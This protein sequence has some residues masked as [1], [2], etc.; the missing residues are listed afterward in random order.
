MPPKHLAIL[1]L[2]LFS[3]ACAPNPPPDTSAPSVTTVP[4]ARAIL[5]TTALRI[6]NTPTLFSTYTPISNTET[7][8]ATFAPTP[9]MTEI[10]EGFFAGDPMI[11]IRDYDLGLY[12][13]NTRTGYRRPLQTQYG[14]SG[15]P[16]RWVN[17]GCELIV[18]VGYLILR[19]DLQGNINRVLFDESRV[20]HDGVIDDLSISPTEAWV[21]YTVKQGEPE[22]RAMYYDVQDIWV[23]SSD[24]QRGPFQLTER[25]GAVGPSQW[26]SDGTLLAYSDWDSNNVSQ[27]YIWSP[28]NNTEIQLTQLTDADVEI[29]ELVLEIGELSWSPDGGRIAFSF[30]EREEH[31]PVTLVGIVS[32][33]DSGHPVSIFDIPGWGLWWHD[34]LTIAALGSYPTNMGSEEYGIHWIDVTTGESTND[35]LSSEVPYG[36]ITMP[37]PL[38][39]SDVGFL[40][41]DNHFY[42]YD[43]ST[44]TLEEQADLRYFLI[45][46]WLPAPASFPGEELCNLILQSTPPTDH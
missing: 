3:T 43:I 7:P 46:E 35:F 28:D 17:N 27:L 8:T 21:A 33:N 13:V 39:D 6:T 19:V 42:I 40:G 32:I 29:G 1:F 16:Y 20:Q 2:L 24:G 22:G 25:G 11:A 34:P 37:H 23:V 44:K 9:S 12:I 14:K 26:N 45:G 18:S 31:G 36:S 38:S 30:N 10:P 41:G 5:T 15:G 4:T